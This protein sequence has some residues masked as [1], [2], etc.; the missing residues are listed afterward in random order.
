MNNDIWYCSLQVFL[1]K[2]LLIFEKIQELLFPNK[3]SIIYLS[4]LP[5]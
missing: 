5:I 2:G 3:I 4:H 1:F